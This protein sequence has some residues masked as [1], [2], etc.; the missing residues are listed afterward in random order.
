MEG[1]TDESSEGNVDFF[2]GGDNYVTSDG[3]S[4]SPRLVRRLPKLTPRR[5]LRID[6][7][8]YDSSG[9]RA[10]PSGDSFVSVH[11]K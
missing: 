9:G 5:N 1:F 6:E 8:K 4:M 7:P 3:E 11:M 2:G 10:G